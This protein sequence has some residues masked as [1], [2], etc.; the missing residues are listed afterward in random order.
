MSSEEQK[1]LWNDALNEIERRKELYRLIEFKSVLAKRREGKWYNFV[2]LI[3]M[4]HSGNLK[5]WEKQLE[6]DNF[7]ILSAVITI[8]QFKEIYERLVSNQV[9]ELDGY[10]AYGP[11]NLPQKDF[12][13]SDQSKRSYDIDWAVNLWRITGKEDFGLPDSRSLELESEGL[14]FSATEDA[15]RYYTGLSVRSDSSLRNA[16]HIVAPLYYAKIKRA[17]LFGR[18][19]FVETGFNLVSAKDLRIKYNTEGL[20]ERSSYYKTIEVGIAELAD[21]TTTI[22]LKEDAEIATVWLYH[23][24]G[25]KIDSR[26]ARR[27]P[28]IED[29]EK[30]LSQETPYSWDEDAHV[31]TDFIISTSKTKIPELVTTEKGVDSIDVEILKAVKT[32]GGDYAKFIPEV[33]KFNSLDMLLSRLARLRTLG[34]LTLQ[35]PRKILLTS[36]GV[37][38]INL[39]P[40]VLSAKIPPEIDKRIAKIKSALKEE[41]YDGVTNKS[42]KLLEALLREKLESKFKGSLEDVWPNL[43]LEPY[44]RASLGTLKEGCIRLN[45]FK[46]NSVVGHLIST[47]LQ[48]RVPMSHEKEEIKSPS[49]IAILTV[50]LIEAFVRN[51]Y[52]LEL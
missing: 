30:H 12:L 23:V 45:I 7:V 8:D 28:S 17:E 11:F 44:D 20:D 26:R 31:I 5:S 51:W 16:I 13:D 42:T 25:F 35:P 52:F 4:L 10:Q 15:I 19:L 24:R 22:Q 47:M 48:L 27:K 14:P 37:D 41:D 3:K 32:K 50:E 34:F 9:L 40:S 49:D 36:L 18:E 29:V 6:K 21:S 2:T 39:P 33:L 43:K 1:P 46:E 38:A